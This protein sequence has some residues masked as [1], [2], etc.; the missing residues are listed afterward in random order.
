MCLSLCVYVLY[1]PW[2]VYSGFDKIFLDLTKLF[3]DET[4]YLDLTIVNLVHHCASTSIPSKSIHLCTLLN[5]VDNSLYIVVYGV[6][7]FSW[8][9]LI[10]LLPIM[11]FFNSL[12]FN[13]VSCIDM[14]WYI[15]CSLWLWYMLMLS[16]LV[17]L[18]VIL[19]LNWM[20]YF[21]KTL[22]YSI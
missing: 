21:W 3:L 16:C 20:E 2:F 18:Y 19:L 1:V 14:V 8:F 4:M 9:I 17:F 6:W 13:I 11:M 12:A 5:S 10:I 22:C 7:Y 15:N